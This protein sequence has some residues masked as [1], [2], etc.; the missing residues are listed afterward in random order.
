MNLPVLL[1]TFNLSLLIILLRMGDQTLL[2][3]QVVSPPKFAN[4]AEGFSI[5]V[6]HLLQ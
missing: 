3:A 5:Q 2:M 6:I 1:S 4:R